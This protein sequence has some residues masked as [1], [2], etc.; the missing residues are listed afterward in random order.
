MAGASC[1]RNALGTLGEADSSMSSVGD[2]VRRLTE[3]G[4]KSCEKCDHQKSWSIDKDG[5]LWGADIECY[6]CVRGSPQPD[7]WKHPVRRE[8]SHEVLPMWIESSSSC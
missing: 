1:A 2:A 6:D 4:E 7:N 8:R 3:M 5:V